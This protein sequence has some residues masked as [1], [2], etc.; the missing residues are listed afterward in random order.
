MNSVANAR[1]I[2]G[3]TESRQRGEKQWQYHWEH[4]VFVT[5]KRKKNFKK[6]YNRTVAKS[7]M[8]E[9]ALMYKIGIKDFSF[10]DD[11]AHVHMYLT[12]P[13]TLRVQDVV[14]ILKSHS[15]SVIFQKIPGFR[16]LYPRGSFWGYQYSNSSFGPA[17][18]TTIVNYIR[19]QDVSRVVN[20]RTL[21]N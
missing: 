6:E 12:I 7:A 9:A 2:K 19:R 14:Q 21:F 13:N 17:T 1:N 10:G 3:S 4:I 15:A 18:E 8:E 11:Y 5:K 16:K 20:Q